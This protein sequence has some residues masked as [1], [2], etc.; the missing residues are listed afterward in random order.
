MQACIREE[1]SKRQR[2]SLAYQADAEVV[3]PGPLLT[4]GGEVK[5]TLVF[6]I[7][8]AHNCVVPRG[9]CRY[10]VVCRLVL[11]Y[12]FLNLRAPTLTLA[13]TVPRMRTW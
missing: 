9:A 3:T 8:S 4:F 6:K 7:L 2:D 1:Y 13:S 11:F 10:S 12:T 5:A